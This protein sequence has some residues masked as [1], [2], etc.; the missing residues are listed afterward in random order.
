MGFQ[1]QSFT[2]T[3]YNEAYAP[4]GSVREHWRYLLDSLQTLGPD[5]FSNRRETLERILRDDGATYNDYSEGLVARPWSL[6]P[7]PLLLDSQEWN[8]IESGVRERAEL[9]DLVMRD[10]YGER[11]LLR[12][13]IIP[14]EL[15][16]SH[17]GFL[18]ECHGTSPPGAQFLIQY[19]ADMVR[20]PDGEMRVIADRTQTPSGGGYAL[21]NRM[22]MARVFP[23]LFRDSH[24]HRLS[25]Y[26]N[27]LRLKLNDLNPNGDVA[28]V[29]VLTPGAYNETYFEH[30]F[31]SNFLGYQLVQGGDLTVRDGYV[32]LKTLDGLSRIDVILRRVDDVYCDPVEL[33]S[34]SQLGVPGLLE[35][36][37]LG[38]VA[39]ANPLGSG[40]LENRA[41]LRYLP[42]AARH[43]LGRELSLQ[44]A[45]TYWCGDADD[46]DYTLNNLDSLVIKTTYRGPDSLLV[47]GAQLD[48]AAL[49]NLADSIR[50]NPLKYVAQQWLEPA[51]IPVSNGGDNVPRPW[52]LRSFAVAGESSYTVMPGGLT[53]VGTRP[54][55][56]EISN[57]LGSTS[58][59]TWVLASEPEKKIDLG[60]IG[61]TG[62]ARRPWGGMELPSRVVENLFWV[63]RYM[64][65]VEAALRLL[66][67][68]LTRLHSLEPFNSAT[69]PVLL[70]AVTHLTG[71][72]PGFMDSA[73]DWAAPDEELL[74]VILDS[75]RI[76]SVVYSLSAL[77]HAVDQVKDFMSA[78][79]QR[80]LN[81]LRDEMERLPRRLQRS[82]GAAPEEELDSLV[83]S[84]LAL[85]GLVQESMV[86]GQG[87]HFLDMGRR[88]ERVLQTISLL[89]S[90]W[91][92]MVSTEDEYPLLETVLVSTEVLM[93]Y[94]RQYQRDLDIANGLDLLLLETRNPRSIIFQLEAIERHLEALP[95][96]PENAR[97]ST[98]QRLLLDASATLRLSDTR[99]LS[100]P[101]EGQYLRGE[102]DQL[103]S[104]LQG[105]VSQTAN[106]L[107]D[108]YFKHTAGPQPM[109][110]TEREEQE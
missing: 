98:E 86:R 97:L 88:M 51:N 84:L 87:W 80:I 1:Q 43:F 102:L 24:V 30:V 72:Y 7:I 10:L 11:T 94:R 40:I 77:L 27:S 3:A 5:E 22:V 101:G 49:E 38:N 46:L 73:S 74:S 109:S 54:G 99:Q 95:G 42:A 105:L 23:S 110:S 48:G 76:G 75:D 91:V 71:T 64:E 16:Y 81:D 41:L 47:H 35:A 103:L 52:I 108:K 9:L 57:K 93:T 20:G 82:F 65:R 44:S 21:E 59:D 13:G 104:R 78:D 62:S 83:T 106:A 4:D 36:V 31:L 63:G 70:R 60:S 2:A 79:T 66:R 68:V 69:G 8:R 100:Q 29:V 15:V 53:R 92:P 17:H 90:L 50:G 28:R 6:D 37:R 45:E 107:T 33:K 89:R 18:R 56:L 96:Q 19:A 61:D 85:A 67:T 34:D 39:V 55:S 12:H 26:F 14:P 25:L 32:W 58:K